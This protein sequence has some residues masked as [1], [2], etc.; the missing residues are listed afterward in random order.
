MAVDYN[1]YVRQ[2]G[3]SLDTSGIQ[4]GIDSFMKNRKEA[5]VHKAKELS[6]KTYSEMVSPWEETIAGDVSEEGWALKASNLANKTP[7]QALAEYQAAAKLKGD[8]VYNQLL[9]SGAFDPKIFKENYKAN[10][11][12]YMPDIERKLESYFKNNHFSEKAKKKFIKDNNLIQ[13]IQKH[14]SDEGELRDLTYSDRTW[15]QW[16]EQKGKALGIGGTAAGTAYGA[17]QVG[18]SAKPLYSGVKRLMGTAPEYSASQIDK[19]S[20][21]MKGKIGKGIDEVAKKSL[22]PAKSALT[23]AQNK[24]SKAEKAYKGK[25]FSSTKEAKNL[26][27]TIKTATSNLNKAESKIGQGSMKV[28]QKYVKKHGTGKLLQVLGKKFGTMGAMRLAGQ[29]GFGT[30]L[31]GTGVGTAVGLGLNALTIWQIASALSDLA[32]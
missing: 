28:I 6:N 5:I 23:K 29:L 12:T 16:F 8:K 18:Y 22:S 21:S 20:K 1:Q 7:G 31:S 24:F 25:K 30:V 4:R 9:S 17:T 3:Q 32:E 15:E 11:A 10:I 14:G 19:L 2:Y 13:L 27:A 26:K